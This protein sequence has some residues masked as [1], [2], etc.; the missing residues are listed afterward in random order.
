MNVIQEIQ[1]INQMELQN[2]SIH[3]PASWHAKYANSAWVY[4]GNLPHE[5]TEGDVICVM[6][7]WGE[8]EDIHLVRENGKP[9][10]SLSYT[11]SDTNSHSSTATA[12]ATNKSKGFGFVKYE[13]PRSCILAVDNFCSTKLLGRSLR[14]D[15]V[16][17][18]RLPKHIIEQEE[19]KEERNESKTGPGHAYHGKQLANSYNIHHGQDLFAT[20]DDLQ[21]RSNRDIQQ[22]D[23]LVQSQAQSKEERKLAKFKRKQE[24]DRIRKERQLRRAIRQETKKNSDGDVDRRR[25]GDIYSHKNV[26]T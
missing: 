2:G 17:T 19:Q 5:L 14:V 7:Q 16:E 22:E 6:S 26:T 8:V 25:H 4:V 12:V 10:K 24:R 3:T 18:Y 1:R 11:K 23:S 15:H 20:P 21:Q 9:N 13:D